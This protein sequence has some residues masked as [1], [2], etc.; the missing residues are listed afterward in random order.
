MKNANQSLCL[1]CQ[2]VGLKVDKLGNLRCHH[3]G[4]MFLIDKKTKK[5]F[6]PVYGE[7]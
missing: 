1:Q 6:K 7:E 3:C 2:S 4:S 5:K